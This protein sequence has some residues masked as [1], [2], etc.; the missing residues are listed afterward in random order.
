MTAQNFSTSPVDPYL[1]YLYLIYGPFVQFFKNL[2]IVALTAMVISNFELIGFFFSEFVRDCHLYD[3][4]WIL[5][6]TDI[7]VHTKTSLLHVGIS[8][9]DKTQLWFFRFSVTL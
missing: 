7:N 5:T 9:K 2:F 4:F 8:R 3:T 6:I 1:F